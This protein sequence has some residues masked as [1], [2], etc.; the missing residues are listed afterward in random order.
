MKELS[1]QIINKVAEKTKY[2]F[3][4]KASKWSK[5]RVV[6]KV[7]KAWEKLC[8]CVDGLFF[9]SGEKKRVYYRQKGTKPAKNRIL[10]S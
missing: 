8:E 9:T 1:K 2:F 3:E 7:C 6:Q 4:N 10:K 5:I